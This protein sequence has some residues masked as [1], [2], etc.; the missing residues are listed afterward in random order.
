[1]AM[2][3]ACQNFS[4]HG[5]SALSRPAGHLLPSSTGDIV[6]SPGVLAL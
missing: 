1:M 4:T 5:L 2:R 6:I 3:I